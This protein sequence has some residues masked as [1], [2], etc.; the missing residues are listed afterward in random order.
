MYAIAVTSQIQL[1]RMDEAASIFR[2][3]VVPAY[4]QLDGFKN[5]YLM[6]DPVSGKS[7]GISVWATE[8][9]RAA[10]QASGALQQQMAKFASVLAA[11]PTPGTYEVKVQV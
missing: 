8:A 9:D 5:A 7:L 6:I 2:D 10:V 1:D 4:Q 3:S 11:Q